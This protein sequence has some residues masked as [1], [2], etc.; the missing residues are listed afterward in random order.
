MILGTYGL[1]R[2]P[3]HLHGHFFRVISTVRLEGSVS[4]DRVKKLE[5]E[6]KVHR[7]LDRAPIKDTI[8][9]PGGGYTI[10]RFLAD[11]PGNRFGSFFMKF[12]VNS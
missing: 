10:V 9:T 2:H 8:K 7:N 6:G 1:S 4:I 3:I 11:N 5:Q 12:I